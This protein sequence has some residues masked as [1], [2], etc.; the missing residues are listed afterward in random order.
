[1][2]KN[3]FVK[4]LKNW[5]Q[6]SFWHNQNMTGVALQ[7]SRELSADGGNGTL[8]KTVEILPGKSPAVE[9]REEEEE[10]KGQK[11]KVQEPENKW[12]QS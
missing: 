2:G 12:M 10:G 8:R 7:F 11:S 6:T 9:G 3:I 4:E 5:K 1:M